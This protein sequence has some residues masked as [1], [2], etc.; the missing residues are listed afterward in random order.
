MIT[1]A[2]LG[3]VFI[4]TTYHFYWLALLSGIATLVAVLWWLWDRNRGNSGKGVQT[5]RPR[6][7]SVTLYLGP[8]IAGLVGDV[9]HDDGRR[10]GIFG[11]GLRL[12]FFLDAACRLSAIQTG[13]QVGPD[14]ADG[15]A[16]GRRNWLGRCSCAR[17]RCMHAAGLR[18]REFWSCWRS[19]P[20]AA[21][22]GSWL[23]G[24]WLSGMDPTQHSYPAILWTLVIWAAVHAGVAII[25]QMFVLAASLA[26]RMTPRYDADIRNVT[27][28]MHFFALTVIVT[29]A[30][31]SLFPQISMTNN[32]STLRRR[33]RV[34]LWTLIVPPIGLGRPFPLLI[35][36]GSN[37][38]R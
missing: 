11:L 1:A 14:V 3:G 22:A 16:G 31:I 26:G 33:L 17:G 24:P 19:V 32:R 20:C 12:L 25:M 27:V 35:P 6:H 21:S 4:F 15:R 38:L 10:Y 34:T 5:D 8:K 29:F 2:A 13:G 7:R 23:I 30:T 37:I 18:W 9:Y 36:L 28:Y